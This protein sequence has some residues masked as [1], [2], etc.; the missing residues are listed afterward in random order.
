MGYWFVMCCEAIKSGHKMGEISLGG[1][2]IRIDKKLN[3]E[4]FVPS[5]TQ[6]GADK[7]LFIDI[8]QMRRSGFLKG[9]S[10]A[11]NFHALIVDHEHHC[12]LPYPS[13]TSLEQNAR[14]VWKIPRDNSVLPAPLGDARNMVVELTWFG[15]LYHVLMLGY[16]LDCDDDVSR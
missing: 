15:L 12:I 10:D 16:L 4:R 6:I 13:R 9:T 5:C 2:I 3:D 8:Q 7:D 14:N 1:M 11:N